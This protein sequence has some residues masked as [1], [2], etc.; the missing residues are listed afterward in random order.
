MSYIVPNH[1][2]TICGCCGSP[3]VK[4][5]DGK[6]HCSL[7]C[8]HWQ[9]SVELGFNDPASFAGWTLI[10]QPPDTPT[11]PLDIH[12]MEMRDDELRRWEQ[13]L[14]E[15]KLHLQYLQNRIPALQDEIRTLTRYVKRLTLITEVYDETPLYRSIDRTPAN[16]SIRIT[17]G[18]I[19]MTDGSIY[20]EA[21][22]RTPIDGAGQLHDADRYLTLSS[23]TCM[24]GEFWMPTYR[25]IIHGIPATDAETVAR[26]W[27]VYATV[28]ETI[29]PA[30]TLVAYRW[31]QG[32]TDA[33]AN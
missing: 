18:L 28:P 21:T 29:R 19:E 17:P 23:V 26:N 6:M 14:R 5:E 3:L 30:G 12:D 11:Y 25:M 27:V 24:H 13:E 33:A 31:I 2:P 9:H 4:G 10:G 32:E 16:E 22:I 8:P 15:K 20:R 1:Y 7:M